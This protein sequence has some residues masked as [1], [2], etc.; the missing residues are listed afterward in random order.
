MTWRLDYWYLYVSLGLNKFTF[1]LPKWSFSSQ[2][3]HAPCHGGP[4]MITSPAHQPPLGWWGPFGVE[5]CN[6]GPFFSG[7]GALPLKVK[8]CWQLAIQITWDG[9]LIDFYHCAKTAFLWKDN[10]IIYKGCPHFKEFIQLRKW[11][12]DTN[13]SQYINQNSISYTYWQ[14]FWHVLWTVM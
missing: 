2:G 7:T 6:I 10:S 5:G 12:I 8:W 4:P 11:N 1:N 9:N 14:C 13:V 3:R